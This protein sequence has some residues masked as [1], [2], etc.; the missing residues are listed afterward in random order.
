MAAASERR[1]TH[2]A[3]GPR[4]RWSW[5][6]PARPRA[7]VGQELLALGQGVRVGRHPAD[8]AQRG[9]RPGHQVEVDVHDHLALDVEVDVE[10]QAVDG[11]AHGALNG[12]LDG[13]E[14]QVDLPAATSSS[15]A[16]MVGSGRRSAPARSGWVSSASW[17]KVA[18]GPK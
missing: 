7:A 2:P 15:T 10:D 14:P 18:A 16:V 3:P 6:P 8:V 12:V 9:A 11:G 13:D 5:P 1:R 4:R 17:V